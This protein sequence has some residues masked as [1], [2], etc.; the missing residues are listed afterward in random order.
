MTGLCCDQLDQ[1]PWGRDAGNCLAI[2]VTLVHDITFLTPQPSWQLLLIG[3]IPTK[4][5]KNSVESINSRLQ[6]RKSGNYMLEYKQTLKMIR[7]GT[8]KLVILAYNCPALR[9]LEVEYY[10]MLAKIGVHHY[11]GNNIEL[12]TACGKYYRVCT[13]ALTDPGDSAI[14]RSIPE[15]T[16][17]K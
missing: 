12:G 16:G 5:V 2:Q 13:L 10:T 1:Y 6:L 8:A 7:Q 15:Q 17:G 4:E 3:A 11:S 14:I 9:K